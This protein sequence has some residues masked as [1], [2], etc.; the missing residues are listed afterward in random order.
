[1]SFAL[2]TPE[3]GQRLRHRLF[4]STK[5]TYIKIFLSDLK[6]DLLRVCCQKEGSPIEEPSQK[7]SIRVDPFMPQIV[8]R[9]WN[10]VFASP[11]LGE[12]VV[13]SLCRAC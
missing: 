12:I 8:R 9:K 5:P 2:N 1:M 7:K 13:V 10:S 3:D 6:L 11:Y 4:F